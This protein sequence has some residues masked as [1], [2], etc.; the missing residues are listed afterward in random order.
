MFCFGFFQ[1]SALHQA[2]PSFWAL[3]RSEIFKW[4]PC[5]SLDFFFIQSWLA[6]LVYIFTVYMCVCDLEQIQYHP[7]SFRPSW[8]Y[9]N[10]NLL[11]KCSRQSLLCSKYCSSIWWW[12]TH[13]I[14]AY[15]FVFL[16]FKFLFHI[17]VFVI[18]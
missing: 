13:T 17:H 3:F 12:P 18:S 4:Q 15:G 2:L 6:P 14:C 10:R 11:T 1:C 8:A 9:Y 16:F 5:L 7:E